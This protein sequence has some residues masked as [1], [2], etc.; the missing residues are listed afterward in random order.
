M[1]AVRHVRLRAGY[2]SASGATCRLGCRGEFIGYRGNYEHETFITLSCKT[3]FSLSHWAL[4]P[5]VV[6]QVR[7]DETLA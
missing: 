7:F 3:S 4:S 1:G 5:V 2:A 6:F